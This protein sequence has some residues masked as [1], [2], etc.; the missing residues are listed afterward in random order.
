[1]LSPRIDSVK[2]SATLGRSGGRLNPSVSS[3]DPLRVNA[4]RNGR[5]PRPHSMAV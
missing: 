1:M 2:D 4:S 3:D 5:A